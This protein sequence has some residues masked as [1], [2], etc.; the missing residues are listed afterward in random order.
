MIGHHAHHSVLS[1]P[2]HT[3]HQSQQLLFAAAAFA[4]TCNSNSNNNNNAAS[5]Y[6]SRRRRRHGR[7]SASSLSMSANKSPSSLPTAATSTSLHQNQF[8]PFLAALQQQHSLSYS[9]TSNTDAEESNFS[10]YS[11]Y[12]VK[13]SNGVDGMGGRHDPQRHMEE[14]EEEELWVDDLGCEDD[15]STCGQQP[16]DDSSSAVSSSSRSNNN[17]P[18][19]PFSILSWNVLAQSLYEGQ[20]QRRRIQQVALSNMS[21]D[22][23]SAQLP[24]LTVSSPHPHPWPKRSKRILEILSHA[25]SDIICLQECELRS[26]KRDLAPRLYDLGYDGISQEDDRPHKPANIKEASKHRDPRNHIAATFWRR[27]KFEVA[28]EASVRTR[29]LTTVLRLKQVAE[30]NNNHAGDDDNGKHVG[31][32]EIST[33]SNPSRPT[34]A[35]INVHLEGHPRRFSERTHQL[36]HAMTD[37]SK[38]IEK[39]R[40]GRKTTGRSAGKEGEDDDIDATTKIGKLNALILAGDFNCELQSSACSAYLRMGR[41]GLQ[42]ALGG[43]HGEDSLSIPPSLLETTEAAEVMH[44]VMEWGRALPEV[45]DLDPHPFRRNGMTSAYPPRLGRDDARE[46]FT[47]CSELSRRPVPGLDQVWFSS[48][49][50][51]RTGLRRMFADDSTRSS[52]PLWERYFYDDAEVER[53]REEERL[54]VL[55][56]GLP[57]P[58]CRYP[59]DHLP[60][61]ATFDWK[62]DTDC[63]EDARLLDDENEDNAAASIM[64]QHCLD[65]AVRGLNVA[66][67][68]GRD[69]QSASSLDRDETPEMPTFDDPHDELDYL[70]R[71]CPYDSEEQRSDVLYILSP[72]DPPISLASKERPTPC[73]LV[74]LDARREKKAEVLEGASLGVRPRLRDI[75][76]ASRRVGK[77]DRRNAVEKAREAVGKEVESV[78]TFLSM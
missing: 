70:V 52:V 6:R 64:Q 47:F 33:S 7:Q 14:E 67:S 13:N 8:L 78:K 30:G 56:T 28:G 29:T 9:T 16:S 63:G 75:W 15:F 59:S 32:D 44:P 4:V 36:Q 20:Y 76:K 48:M 54:G 5:S 22:R 25:N 35:I 10:R 57:C 41:L 45:E 2:H 77:W 65:G 34:V 38:R 61:G 21:N 53:R 42:S 27:D 66:D 46:H 71:R 11:K 51:R 50:L 40:E 17:A 72:I 69:L 37:L 12:L 60:I 55:A 19:R 73:Q 1:S 58:E 26:F 68:E 18:P 74:Q 43:I 49:T 31:H 62:W 24:S 39:E 23:H 3:S